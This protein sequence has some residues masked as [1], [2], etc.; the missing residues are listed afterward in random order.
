MVR[1]GVVLLLFLLIVT[2]IFVGGLF[3]G[4]E[5]GYRDGL[6]TASTLSESLIQRKEQEVLHEILGKYQGNYTDN[7][8]YDYDVI[9]RL[10][11]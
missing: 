8:S 1:T 4:H 7:E 10:F 6:F 2:M 3:I 9:N 5:F 11:K